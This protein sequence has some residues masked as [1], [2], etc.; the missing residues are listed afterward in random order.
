VYWNPS[1]KTYPHPN[2]RWYLANGSRAK[3]YSY[4]GPLT[5]P[6]A[7]PHPPC[8]RV[9]LTNGMMEEF[10]CTSDSIQYYVSP[11]GVAK[12]LDLVSAW[13]LDMITDPSGNQIHFTYMSHTGTKDGLSYPSD[14]ELSTIEWDSPNCHDAQN[15]CTG[16]NW[17]P[18]MRVQFL[19]SHTVART[20]N[21]PANCNTGS[22]ARCDNPLDLSGSPAPEVQVSLAL[23]DINVQVRSSGSASW[24][25]LKDYQLSYEVNG[26]SQ[27]NDPYTNAAVS[28][29]GYF[30]LTRIKV[31]GDDGTTALPTRSFGYQHIWEHY[32]DSAYHSPSGDC[33]PSWNTNCYLWG[34][35][36]E[37]GSRYLVSADNGMGLHQQFT[38]AEARNNTHGVNGSGDPEDPLYCTGKESQGYPCNLADDENWSHIVLTKEDDSVVRASSAGN[39][40]VTSTTTFTYELSHLGAQPCSD[41]AYGYDWGDQNDFDYAD[42][43]NGKFMGFTEVT[44]NN[45][46][47]S[48][49]VHHYKDTGGWGVYDT[50]K[51]TCQTPSPCHNAPWWDS[52]TALHGQEYE[53]DSYDTNGSTLL[54]QVKTQYLL[55]CPP[56]GVSGTPGFGPGQLRSELD[57]GNPVVAC[58]I[59]PSQVDTYT[60]DG[61]SNSTHQTVT[62][63]YDSYQRVT[64]ETTTTN[65]GTPGTVVKNTAYVWNNTV[66]SSSNS[67]TGTYILDTPAFTDVEDGSGNRVSCAYLSYDG[68]GYTTGQTSNLT[69]GL[70]TTHDTYTDCG[71]SANGYTPSGKMTTTSVYDT[72]GNVIATTDA[73]ANAGIAGHTGCSISGTSYTTCTTYDSTFHTLKVAEANALNQTTTTS[74]ANTAA[75]GFGLWPISVTDFNGQSTT[76]AYDALGRETGLTL[77]GEGSGLTTQ[78][79]TF[80][81]WCA[82]TGAQA[83]CVEVDNTQRLDSS[84]T[85]TSRDFYD[86]YGDLVETRNA[87]PA[88][89]DVVAYAHYDATGHLVFESNSYFV[90]AYT[91]GPGSAAFSAPDASQV[92]TTTAYD[93]LERTKSVIDP[94]SQTTTTAFSVLC[95][96]PGTSDTGCYEQAT[97][98]D[99]NQHQRA[100][101]TNGFGQVSYDLRYTGTGPYTLA[102]TTSYQYDT[103]G[104]LISILHPDKTTTTTFSFN[105]A[106]QKISQTDPDLGT[107]S[108][109]YDPNGNLIQTVDARGSAGTIYAGYDGLNRLLWRGTTNSPSGAQASYTYDSTASGNFGAGRKTGE[110][111]T[112]PGGLSGSYAYTYD[113]RGQQTAETV[114]VN[115]QSYTLRKSYDDA[116][117]VLSET[118]PT[119]ETVNVGYTQ[120]W[121]AQVSTTSGSTTT[122]LASQ[123]QYTGSAG[124]ASKITGM[125]LGNGVY[126]YSASYDAT[127]RLTSEQIALTNGGTVLFSSQPGYDAVGNVTSVQTALAGATDNQQFCYNEQNQLIWAGS[128][129][130]P[131]CGSLTAGTLTA[132]QYQQSYSYDLNGRLTSGPLGTYTYGDPNHVHAVTST[133]GG[134]SASYDAAGNMTCRAPSSATT[135][136]GS[137]PSGQQLSYD[138]AGRLAT[139]GDQPTPTKTVNY[140][141]DGEGNRV[142]MQVSASGTTTTTAYI[143]TVEEVQTSGSTTQTTTYY[144]AGDQRI[145]EA[146][147]GVFSY[148][149]SDRLGSPV[150]A[151][152]S[153]G[154]VVATQL[155]GP[156]GA[157]RYKSGTMP[158]SIGFTGQH[159][160]DPTGLDYFVSRYYDP[161]LGAF[162]SP[163][164]A[165]PANGYNPWGLSR[166]TYVQ[167]NPETATDPDGHC[168]P[169]CTM[170]IGAIVGAVVGAAVSV[171]TQAASGHC[172]NWGEV[173]KQ[174]AVG[175]VSGAVSGLAGPEAGLAVHAAVGAASGAAGQ[176]V[177]NLIDHKPIGDGVLEAAAIGGITGVAAEG[178]GAV[179][180]KVASAAKEAFG[181]AAE[182]AENGISEA[183]ESC[184]L[185][186]SANTL[187]ATP[188][189]EQPISSLRVGEHVQAY[190]PVT[191]KVSTQTVQQVFI[192]H[193]TDLIDITLQ[194]NTPSAPGK[195]QH[196]AVKSHGSQA[197]PQTVLE[198]VHTTQKHPWL[199]TR[200]WITAG[201][202]HLGN[203]VQ[204]LDG[205][206]ATVI[207]LKVVA[208]TA[209]MY[210]L[211]VSNVHT[212]A[213]GNGQFVVHNCGEKLFENTMPE[214]LDM[215]L[216]SAKNLGVEPMSPDDPG[217]E[218]LVNGG[219]VKWAVTKEGDLKFIPHDVNGTEI[220]HTVI[221]GGEPVLAAGE[222]DISG[223]GGQY[224]VTEIT[225]HSGHYLPDMNSLENVAKPLFRKL[226]FLGL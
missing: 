10:G 196:V 168:W 178:A 188:G 105:A 179:F 87:G 94:N 138:A 225:Y 163:D 176:M 121:L 37:S 26:P 207:G 32:E 224:W 127:K 28:A 128:T 7:T 84:T 181:S 211:T 53:V 107:T 99:A 171:G 135:C 154:A 100:T 42:Y 23:N 153:T 55:T 89:Q 200:G 136:S 202:L 104:D 166:Y 210:D 206:T 30:D 82:S 102:A 5:L 74:Y 97:M 86:G 1:T 193:D 131:P 8:F 91:G 93:G 126:T 96:V 90:T 56:S 184:G 38:Y 59:H 133:S 217:F 162:I 142:A 143:D 27:I 39:T 218:D 190:D 112:G 137:S 201:Q 33:G 209:A 164:S 220:Y 67:A 146:V 31:V 144:F 165:L 149:G 208:G 116:G 45:P 81:D 159:A 198:T 186:F 150:V 19:A 213:V 2:L 44:V 35:S 24:N 212:F 12:D 6:N 62:T 46:D 68:Q 205:Q 185:S 215:E 13:K 204:L 3:I 50:S 197:P 103:S 119:G 187:V 64:Q 43:Y 152:S 16:S 9:F 148:L 25:T 29:A 130:T 22:F 34:R 115:G 222:A 182:D 72:Y 170:I 108:Y 73:D 78:S 118:Y 192:N 61:G 75:G 51:V 203:E 79:W 183:A 21:S 20:T 109:S 226:G 194:V 101:L 60:F 123:I 11:S 199:T 139:W 4:V 160:D 180:K 125:Q 172:C 69:R 18:L 54:K 85:V 47:G 110:S 17:A 114:T 76:H 219:K 57:A 214:R 140:L 122:N 111:F 177:S 174:A 221:T 175:A 15:R 158:G 189:G 151:L 124:A 95:S 63:T 223:A 216:R 120:G 117:H 129:G 161:S 106:G 52:A 49:Q 155:Y 14:V 88:G 80:T 132:A 92:G 113:A 58:S 41:C 147:N 36:G 65:G 173:G 70:V 156:Y 169:L 141:Y 191:K 40:T 157:S 71:T 98:V 195:V 145:A 83:P 134:Y 77:P 167:G 66:S 48:V